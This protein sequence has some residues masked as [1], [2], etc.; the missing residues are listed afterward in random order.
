MWQ[1]QCGGI[2]QIP[3][4]TQLPPAGIRFPP[5]GIK[6]PPAGTQLP[7]AGMKIPPAGTQLPPAGIRFSPAGI[8]IPPTGMQ[9]P[10][11][12]MKISPAGTQFSPAGTQ[13]PPAGIQIPPVNSKVK[14]PPTRGSACPAMRELGVGQFKATANTILSTF[15]N[16]AVV[17]PRPLRGSACPAMREVGEGQQPT[18]KQEL[19]LILPPGALPVPQCGSLGWG[20]NKPNFL[21]P[22]RQQEFELRARGG[23]IRLPDTFSMYYLLE[24]IL[25]VILYRMTTSSS[26]ANYLLF[27]TLL[28]SQSLFCAT[29]PVRSMLYQFHIH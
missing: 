6:I 18:R 28:R 14:L 22:G 3:A 16:L 7:P 4:G 12:G 2:S 17:W 8:K 15:S 20:S 13:L 25:E 26:T 21:L 29:K 11:A 23:K 5:A 19:M 10:P 24:V 1:G 9:L 27:M